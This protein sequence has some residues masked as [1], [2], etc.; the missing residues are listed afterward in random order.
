MKTRRRVTAELSAE[1][2]RIISFSGK[3][4][5]VFYANVER[6]CPG[7][8]LVGAAAF[9]AYGAGGTKG[10]PRSHVLRSGEIFAL[11]WKGTEDAKFPAELSVEQLPSRQG[12]QLA[13]VM[14]PDQ[15]SKKCSDWLRTFSGLP[16]APPA[17]SITVVWPF[18]TNDL[19]LN[20]VQCTNSDNILLSANRMPA[21]KIGS[22]PT[23]LAQ[24]S[25]TEHTATSETL[26]PALFTLQPAGTDFLKVTAT[27]IPEL[28]KFFSFTPIPTFTHSYSAIEFTFRSK[29][30][31]LQVATLH[32]KNC[33]AIVKEAREQ[34]SQLEHFSTPPGAKGSL[35]I[36]SPFG[37]EKYS[38]QPGEEISPLNQTMRLVPSEILIKLRSAFADPQSNVEID[39]GGFGRL[40][41]PGSLTGTSNKRMGSYLQPAVR[42]R[43]LCFLRQLQVTPPP[44]TSGDDAALVCTL[45]L[46]KPEQKL[47]PHYRALLKEILSSGFEI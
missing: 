37:R 34:E 30:G 2:Y 16:I 43:L 4:D 35:I 18:L 25:S 7:L 20:E 9:S 42:N 13:L 22:G 23:M 17:P 40:Y 15:I 38:I 26:S 29:A 32:K 31:T 27:N 45:S 21:N 14:I 12:W 6:E 8:P 19:S 46:V 41:L 3:P 47:L 1:P 33:V 39:F 28:E 10:F 5:P 24:N 11:L 44:I 36:E